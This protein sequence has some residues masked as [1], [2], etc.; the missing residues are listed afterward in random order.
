MI[1]YAFI[2]EQMMHPDTMKMALLKFLA[3]NNVEKPSLE[4]SMAKIVYYDQRALA[5]NAIVKFFG[6]AQ[7]T[8]QNTNMKNGVYTLPEGEHLAVHAIR[9][10][11]GA[12][13]TLNAID[14]T[15]GADT[16]CSINSLLKLTRNNITQLNLLPLS[17][18]TRDLTTEDWGFINFPQPWL[19]KGQTSITVEVQTQGTPAANESLRVEIHGFGL[20]S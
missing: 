3:A 11:T 4:K 13:A 16:A 10:L 19:W 5:A 14:W 9:I 7:G 8:A 2:A 18:G 6:D 17:A 1:S 20:I 12:G 15:Y